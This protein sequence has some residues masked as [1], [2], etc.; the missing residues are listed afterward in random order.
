[1]FKRK[2]ENDIDFY[3]RMQKLTLVV[4][5]FLIGGLFLYTLFVVF[6]K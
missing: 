5:S 4:F 6:F 3:I 1:M 2:N